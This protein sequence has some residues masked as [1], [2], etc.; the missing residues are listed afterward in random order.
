MFKNMSPQALSLSGT[1]S[2]IIELV[3][4]YGFESMDLDAIEF[5]E[6]AEVKGMDYARRLID[7]AKMKLGGFVL[8]IDL[9]ADDA[10][11][12]EA[13][14]EVP[15]YAENMAA[16]GC[17]RCWAAV[18]PVSTVMPY[19]ENFERHRGRLADLTGKLGEHGVRLGLGF[20]GTEKARVAKDGA[21]ALEF[22]HDLDA[23]AV[24]VNTVGAKNLGVIV[25]SWHLFASG[26]TIDN[27]K[28]LSVEQIVGVRV[29]DAPTDVPRDALVDS[30]RM[31]P[32]TTGLTKSAELLA[33][34]AEMGYEGPVTPTPHRSRF[35]G[36]TRDRM[37][38]SI[39]DAMSSLWVAAGLK[40][41]RA[42]EAEPAEAAAAT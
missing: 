13:T 18:A 3:L 16:V 5:S 32:G 4:T 35:Q 2:E 12:A 41:A 10:A 19:H 37:V 8:P 25:D 30:D 15:K 22:I 38:R 34:L 33:A 7:S 42:A 26:G 29:A 36:R 40:P 20:N 21:E 31:V 39:G 9:E 6:R 24:L 27:V 1:Q 14:A 17:T 28:K 11:F 23:L